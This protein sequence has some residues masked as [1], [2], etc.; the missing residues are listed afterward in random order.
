MRKI[1]RETMTP[2][3]FWRRALSGGLMAQL[4]WL[5]SVA[6]IVPPTVAERPSCGRDGRSVERT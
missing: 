6:V 5:A 4:D 3:K 1:D 2:L